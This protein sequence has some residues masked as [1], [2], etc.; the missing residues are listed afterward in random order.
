MDLNKLDLIL[1]IGMAASFILGCRRGF[2]LQ[3]VS[4][5]GFVVA[6]ITAYLFY[7]DVVPWVAKVIPVDA[8]V[9]QTGFE[10]YLKGIPLNQYIAAAISFSLL[11]FGVK[12]ILTAAGHVLNILVRVPGLN[13]LNRWAGGLL[14]LVE[15]AIAAF[16]VIQIMAVLPQTGVQALLMDST[17]ARWSMEWAPVLFNKMKELPATVM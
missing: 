4:M 15:A 12:L 13:M 14:A 2:V 6:W 3:L 5:L 1:V 16:I 7:D 8:F 9:S 17:A 10:S 11:L